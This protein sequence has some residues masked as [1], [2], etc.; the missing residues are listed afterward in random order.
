MT[1]TPTKSRTIRLVIIAAVLLVIVAAG[2]MLIPRKIS[3]DQTP[4]PA[5]PKP[6][7]TNAQVYAAPAKATILKIA[8]AVKAYHD[9]TNTWPSTVPELEAKGLLAIP[10]S[11]KLWWQFAFTG[12]P[13]ASYSAMSTAFMPDG[14]FRPLIYRVESG[15]WNGYGADR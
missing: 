1:T 5:P 4:P 15:K 10:D 12:Q 2:V 3:Q 6:K 14:P 9:Q 7:P 13:P 8:D 11:V